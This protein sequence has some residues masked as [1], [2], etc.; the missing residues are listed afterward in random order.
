MSNS[1]TLFLRRTYPD[2]EAYW[3]VIDDEGERIAVIVDDSGNTPERCAPWTWGI[4]VFGLPQ[5]GNDRGREWTREAA[6]AKV[7]SLWLDYKARYTPEEYERWRRFMRR[8]ETP[9]GR[10]E[11]NE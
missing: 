11:R 7:K 3:H 5:T 4:S 2:S 1:P 9:A 8:H 10:Q 6:M